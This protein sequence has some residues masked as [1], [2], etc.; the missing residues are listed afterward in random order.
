MCV[1]ARARA[2]S[3]LS[4]SVVSNSASPWTVALQAP[5]SMGFSRQ[6]YCYHAL[7]QRIFPNP[8]IGPRSPALQEESLC[9]SHPLLFVL[10]RGDRIKVLAG[11]WQ[12]VNGDF[13]LLLISQGVVRYRVSIRDPFSVTLTLLSISVRHWV[14][15]H[16]FWLGRED[17]RLLGR[18][19]GFN[20]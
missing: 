1:C 2:R 11:S 7:L 14:I 6:E 5:L 9:L 10:G 4:R 18:K 17:S 16:P 13:S 20:F 19:G 15:L 8:G 12:I 3:S